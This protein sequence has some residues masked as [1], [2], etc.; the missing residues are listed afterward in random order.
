LQNKMPFHQKSVIGPADVNSGMRI[1]YR[2]KSTGKCQLA[3]SP[4]CVLY[5]LEGRA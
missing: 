4:L 1:E 2:L 3:G 5:Y